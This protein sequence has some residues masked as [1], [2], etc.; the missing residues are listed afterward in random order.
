MERLI[1]F[2]NFWTG[3][4]EERRNKWKPISLI[5]QGVFNKEADASM[6][7]IYEYN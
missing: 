6:H 2:M 1:S 3:I 4:L 7:L 5:L